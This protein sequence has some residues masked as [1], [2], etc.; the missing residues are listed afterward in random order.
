M[1]FFKVTFFGNFYQNYVLRFMRQFRCDCQLRIQG[2]ENKITQHGLIM[3]VCI[4][5]LLLSKNA[6]FLVSEKLLR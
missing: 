4:V 3:R 1:L 6:A 5:T 2:Q